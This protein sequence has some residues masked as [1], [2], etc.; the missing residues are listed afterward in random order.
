LVR[1]AHLDVYGLSHA[2]AIEWG[3]QERTVLVY[4]PR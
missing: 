1:G 3:V 4:A 2:D